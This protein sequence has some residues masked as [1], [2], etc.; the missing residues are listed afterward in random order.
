MQSRRGQ[1]PDGLGSLQRPA[2]CAASDA[3]DGNSTF[4]ATLSAVTG[5][6][7]DDGLGSQTA[8][9]SY[10]DAGGLVVVGSE[11]YSIFDPTAPVI[12]HVLNPAAPTGSNGWYTGDVSLN[13]T[14]TEPESPNSLVP[15]GCVDRS[16]TTDQA[17]LRYDTTAGQFVQ[18]WK[19][20]TG[21]GTC[22]KVTLTTVDDSTTAALFK[23]K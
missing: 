11:T 3:E 20:P 4:P 6:N 12:T 5:P 7:A 10:T 19:T 13:W 15:T 14:V 16:I 22:Y 18:N 8:S 1:D 2:T 17:C 23:L 21:A 9:C